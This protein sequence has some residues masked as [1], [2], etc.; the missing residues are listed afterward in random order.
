MS[1]H[2]RG[3][4][5]I[6][7]LVV[8]SIIALLIGL[9]LPA[10]AGAWR[11]AEKDA[12][13]ANL[14]SLGQEF[15]IYL[16]SEN[17]SIFPASPL[18]PTVNDPGPITTVQGTLVYGPPPIQCVVGDVQPPD[19]IPTPNWVPSINEHGNPAVWRCPAD[20]NPFTAAGPPSRT[21]PSY[22]SAEGTSYQYN[23]LLA[24]DKLE[25]LRIRLPNSLALSQTLLAVNTPVLADM[26]TFHGPSGQPGSVNVLYGDWHVGNASSSSGVSLLWPVN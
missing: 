17:H 6:E 11:V 9:L 25:N 23:M 5:I 15:Q 13:A 8:I 3:F 20:T 12:C 7:L 26:S 22:F 16:Q 1:V 2:R 18:M 24:G 19:T 4:T 10:L 14:H 21:Y